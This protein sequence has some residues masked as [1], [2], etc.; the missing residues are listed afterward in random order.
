MDRV[1]FQST[2]LADPRSAAAALRDDFEEL[3]RIFDRA[4]AKVQIDAKTR[5]HI[6]GAKEAAERG[7][8][9]SQQLAGLLLKGD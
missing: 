1:A 8:E 5:P 3:A 4:L 6:A 2:D 7:I 9:L